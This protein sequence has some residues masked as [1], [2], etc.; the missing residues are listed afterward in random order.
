ML[1]NAEGQGVVL[2]ADVG[3]SKGLMN[4]YTLVVC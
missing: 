4:V 3:D 1:T 2:A